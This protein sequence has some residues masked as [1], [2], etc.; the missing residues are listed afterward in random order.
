MAHGQPASPRAS[1][2]RLEAP[3]V[4]IATASRMVTLA[5]GPSWPVGLIC[6]S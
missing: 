6:C 3:P 1:R 2:G 5:L 4:T